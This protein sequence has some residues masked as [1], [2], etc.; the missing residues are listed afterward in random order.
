M[1]KH[2]TL[3]SSLQK[4]YGFERKCLSSMPIIVRDWT[5]DV[6]TL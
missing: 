6:K 4:F 5:N 2:P 1:D 3:E